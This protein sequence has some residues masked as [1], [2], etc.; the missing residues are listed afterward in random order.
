MSRRGRARRDRAGAHAQSAAGQLPRLRAHVAH[1]AVAGVSRAD[2]RRGQHG[3]GL[4]RDVAGLRSLEP[5]VLR[6]V[7]APSRTRSARAASAPS[8]TRTCRWRRR[9]RGSPGSTTRS[10]SR[11]CRRCRRMRAP[12]RSRGCACARRSRRRPGGTFADARRLLG[13]VAANAADRR[14]RERSRGRRVPRGRRAARGVAARARRRGDDA[15]RR[16]VLRSCAAPSTPARPSTP[17]PCAATWRAR[18]CCSTA[19]RST[20]AATRA[21]RSS[22][23]WRSRCAK[24]SRSRC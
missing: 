16:G 13:E 23:R 7:A 2:L 1:P 20:R 15:H 8:P 21:C 22:R 19:P 4:V 10:S 24:A 12:M 18:P 3:H 9:R 17:T 6:R 11:N 5:R 14:A